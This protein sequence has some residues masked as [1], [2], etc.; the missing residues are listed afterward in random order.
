MPDWKTMIFILVTAF[1][2]FFF[3]EARYSPAA[4][5]SDVEQVAFRLDQKILSDQLEATQARIWALQDRYPGGNMPQAVLEEYRALL[6]RK[7]L[8]QEKLKQ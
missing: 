3:F 7:R 1:S 6:E 8:L 5:S 4:L 2:T